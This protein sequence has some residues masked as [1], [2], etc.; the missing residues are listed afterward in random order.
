MKEYP[1]GG[2]APGNYSCKCSTCKKTFR[3]DKRA[4]QCEPCADQMISEQN[5]ERSVATEDQSSNEA[6]NKK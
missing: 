3:G 6:D 1:I 2:F 4:V 5:P